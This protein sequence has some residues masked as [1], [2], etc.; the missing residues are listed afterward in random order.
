MIEE[1]IE[2]DVDKMLLYSGN[3][4]PIKELGLFIHN[5]KLKEVALLTE[6]GYLKA[7]S[8]LS[9]K[10]EDYLESKT[11]APEELLRLQG[12]T[13]LD[14][15]FSSLYKK[16][17]EMLLFTNLFLI[18]FP[19]YNVELDFKSISI[20]FTLPQ[21]NEQRIIK[22]Q[23]FKILRLYVLE[24][25]G[26]NKTKPKNTIEPSKLAQKI[27]ADLERA[28]EKID[29]QRNK[30]RNGSILFNAVSCCALKNSI[31]Y[32]MENYTIT[33]LYNELARLKK[34]EEYHQLIDAS[35]V[36]AKLEDK[37]APWTIEDIN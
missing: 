30:D 14:F 23:D 16:T 5:P 20:I 25:F 17:E 11:I 3:D 2:I 37:I 12:L 10:K 33:Q 26:L 28:H 29:K 32:I 8:I 31:H 1:T 22:G 21:T 24:L 7:L 6:K 15:V 19:L 4:I 27:K 35:L 34:Y 9:I 36:G 18:L 13:D